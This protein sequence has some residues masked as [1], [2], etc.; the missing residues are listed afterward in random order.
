[1]KTL[2]DPIALGPLKLN[3]RLIRSATLEI[4]GAKDGKITPLL[5]DVMVELTEGGVG[6]IITGMMGVGPNACGLSGMVRTYDESFIPAMTEVVNAVHAK[7]GK[8]VIQ[9]S[10]CGVKARIID[11]MAQTP[12]GP[13]DMDLSGNRQ[14]KAMTKEQIKET[15]DNF[16]NAA[17]RCKE[18]G[19]DG[20]QIHGGHGYGI[21]QFLSPYYNKRTDNYGG[22]IENRA[23][24]LLEACTA[25]REKVG[26]NYPL[27]VKINATDLVDESITAEECLY[28]CKELEK[29]GVTAV[30]ISGGIAADA[31]S[32]ALQPAATESREGYFSKYALMI[33]DHLKIPVISVGGYRTH[34]L[35][36]ET[37]NK[38]NIT[39]MSLSR[40]LIQESGL[41]NRWKS[42]DFSKPK[43]V[44]CSKCFTSRQHGCKIFG[45]KA[46][47]PE[48]STATANCAI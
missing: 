6:L 26:P 39:A 35:M 32:S 7:G 9:L 15:V 3:N 8:I 46:A 28:V 45:E 29:I 21:S 14:A 2:F 31:K 19:A 48:S 41:P 18:T 37:L 43:C 42:G 30:E 47:T 36:E 12:L 4:G 11:G 34:R 40:P 25:I 10:H 38:G 33:A 5:K 20:V 17:L 24:I 23:R 1:M 16:A 27:L 13:S 44:S 22:P